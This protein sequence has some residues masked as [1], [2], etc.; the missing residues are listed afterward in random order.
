MYFLASVSDPKGMCVIYILRAMDAVTRG[1]W[2]R[3]GL[4]VAVASAAAEL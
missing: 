1:E 4:A 2:G 3:G